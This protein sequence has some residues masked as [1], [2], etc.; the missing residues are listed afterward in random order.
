MAGT[1]SRSDSSQA[2]VILDKAILLFIGSNERRCQRGTETP[3]WEDVG[4]AG[5]GP[6][7]QSTWLNVPAPAPL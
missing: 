4:A 3:I 7:G 5:L 6:H 1:K 2:D